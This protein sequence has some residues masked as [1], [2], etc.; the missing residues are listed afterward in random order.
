MR[1]QRSLREKTPP[2]FRSADT[3]SASAPPE[4][5]KTVHCPLALFLPYYA[6][7]MPGFRSPP[8]TPCCDAIFTRC[9]CLLILLRL[10]LRYYLLLPTSDAVIFTRGAM[11]FIRCDH[12]R[13][14]RKVRRC[15]AA[16]HR[17]MRRRAGQS[18]AECS[19]V[20]RTKNIKIEALM[21]ARQTSVARRA[22]QQEASLITS[23]LLLR[24]QANAHHAADR[25]SHIYSP[26]ALQTGTHAQI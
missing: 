19:A 3:Q 10:K 4:Q 6:H 16:A 18:G 5:R 23:V 26:T 7:A 13:A 9:R 8:S 22:Q 12:Q 21:L 1:K 17:A 14:M 2:F 20:R 25:R 15:A 24:R 11:L